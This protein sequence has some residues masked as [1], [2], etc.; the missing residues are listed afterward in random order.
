MSE[1]QQVDQGLQQELNNLDQKIDGGQPVEQAE[2]T[3]SD[4]NLVEQDGE[5]LLS[6]DT[7]G[8]EPTQD[9]PED[10]QASDQ[11]NLSN[12]EEQQEDTSYQEP[13][14]YQGKSREDLAEMLSNAQSKIG[15]QGNELGELRKQAEQTEAELTD[16]EVFAKLGSE[17]IK[18]LLAEEKAKYNE[19]DPYEEM[20]L[21]EQQELI[22]EMESDLITKTTEEGIRK[23]YDQVDN[24]NF[25]SQQKEVFK[26]QGVELSDTEFNDVIKKSYEY[27]QNGRLTNNSVFKAMIDAFGIDQVQKHYRMSGEAKARQEIKNAAAK[28]TERVDVRGSGKSAKLVNINNLKGQELNKALDNLSIDDL[29]KLNEKYNRKQNN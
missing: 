17:D 16:S 13:D 21:K 27:S 6:V 9:A 25:V 22:S 19:I 3:T 1:E 24:E 2:T 10:G 7:D 14:A 8:E 28:T 18:M 29:K 20:A 5:L 12:S 4:T 26:K 23:R 15:V 11:D